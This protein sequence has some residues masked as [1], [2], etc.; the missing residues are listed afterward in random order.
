MSNKHNES[1]TKKPAYKD[2]GGNIHLEI[3]TNTCYIS[4]SPFL[5]VVLRNDH[6][7]KLELTE[8]VQ[9]NISF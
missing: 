4:L 9:P 6:N 7:L 1:A 3:I 8:A 2:N 5:L